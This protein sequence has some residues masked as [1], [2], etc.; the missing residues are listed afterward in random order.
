MTVEEFLPRA[1]E[2]WSSI[3]TSRRR[4]PRTGIALDISPAAH[5]EAV[6]EFE[7]A[8]ALDPNLFEAY[9]PLRGALIARRRLGESGEMLRARARD[10]SR[11]LPLSGSCSRRCTRILDAWRKLRRRR[12]AASSWRSVRLASNPDVPLAATLGAGALVR[13]GERD[14][15]SRMD[16][17]RPDDRPRRSADALQRRLRLRACSARRTWPS[18]CSSAGSARAKPGDT[19]LDAVATPIST[20]SATIRAFRRFFDGRKRIVYCKEQELNYAD[21]GRRK[22]SRSR[23]STWLCSLPAAPSP[24]WSRI[25]ATLSSRNRS[26]RTRPR[27]WAKRTSC[28]TSSRGW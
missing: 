14:A 12:G 20:R 7:R 25:A 15:R 10:R 28:A 4:T 5:I 26:I 8:I 16:D 27:R 21:E 9:L 11:R 23:L 19:R 13:L 3:R 17:A 6:A 24:R 22:G 1:Q 2:R 18:I